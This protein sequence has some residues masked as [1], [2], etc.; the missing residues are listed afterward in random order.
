MFKG[1][2][3]FMSQPL[4]QLSPQGAGD[5]RDNQSNSDYDFGR[6]GARSKNF[7]RSVPAESS[8][9]N[10]EKKYGRKRPKR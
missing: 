3:E 10:P 6:T 1:F 5:L 4:S 7:A 9:L 8:G 2:R